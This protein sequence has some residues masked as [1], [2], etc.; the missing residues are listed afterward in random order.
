VVIGLLKIGLVDFKPQV[1]GEVFFE[2]GLE[3]IQQAFKEF[4]VVDD[5]CA[6]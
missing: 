1:V 2:E 3:V 4:I 5:V 6:A